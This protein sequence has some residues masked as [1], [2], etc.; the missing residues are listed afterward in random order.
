VKPQWVHYKLGE[1]IEHPCSNVLTHT[2]EVCKGT[3]RYKGYPASK[4]DH[5][6][7]GICTTSVECQTV[8]TAM[9]TF[10]SDMD[11]H[12]ISGN[13]GW[14]WFGCVRSGQSCLLGQSSVVDSLV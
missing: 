1:T 12:M 3:H 11:P 9:L 5:D 7:W 6:S 14:A 13:L 2:L 8:M 10:M 4:D